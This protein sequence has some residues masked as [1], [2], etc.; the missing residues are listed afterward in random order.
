MGTTLKTGYVI[1]ALL[2]LCFM[3]MSG[4]WAQDV[5]AY[6]DRDTVYQGDTVNLTIEAKGQI[7]NSQPDLDPLSK[8][9]YVLGTS[10]KSQVQIINGRQSA[11]TSWVVQ[12]EP[13]HSGD[14]KIPALSVA[15]GKTAPLKLTVSSQPQA[16]ARQRSEQ[17][18]VEAKIEQSDPYVQAQIRYTVRLYYSV[19]LLDGGLSDPQPEHAMV[20]R[21]GDDKSFQTTLNGRRYQVLERSYA[22]FPE[23]SGEFSIPPVRFEGRVA[24][25]SGRRSDMLLNSPFSSMFGS[26]FDQGRRVG[27]YSDA[28]MLNV[29]PRPDGYTGQYWLPAEKL[30]LLEAWSQDPPQFRVGEPVTRTIILD[31]KG[32]SAA[33]LPRIEI[34]KPNRANV[35]PEQP[36]TENRTDGDW[37]FG[38]LEQKIAIVPTAEGKLTLPEI[39]LVWWDTLNN[40][41]QVAILPAKDIS[42]LPGVGVAAAPAQSEPAAIPNNSETN[43]SEAVSETSSDAPSDSPSDIPS[44]KTPLATLSHQGA[45]A[46]YWPWIVG[47]LLLAWLMTIGAWIYVN[48]RRASALPTTPA[49]PSPRTSAVRKALQ[50][51]CQHNNAEDAAKALLDWAAVLWPIDTPLN[52]GELA[53]RLE[54][55]QASAVRFLDQILYAARSERWQGAP[56]WKAVK[57]GLHEDKRVARSEAGEALQP[58]YPQQA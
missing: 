20:E 4:A 25:D 52:L 42:V 39:K 51:A 28:V 11:T 10:T 3:A 7:Q 35:Y 38:H 50:Y 31:A 54:P 32:Q 41:Q 58:L 56:L 26:M 57:K 17:L 9:F 48:R 19:P 40:E 12:L 47:G 34:P 14:I 8:D 55:E 1:L 53:V 13:K 24:D 33:H 22:I 21:L 49:T 16:V 5:S 37:L 2:T 45:N 18:F 36:T 43:A 29:Q 6:F 15:G 30:S 44:K 23:Q 27:A 46:G